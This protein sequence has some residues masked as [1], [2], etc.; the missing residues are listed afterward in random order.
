MHE[1]LFLVVCPDDWSIVFYLLA[2]FP[3]PTI[4][5]T[6]RWAPQAEPGE[7]S[8]P[9][10]TDGSWPDTG[11]LGWT[12]AKSGQAHEPQ[13]R[14]VG[15][16]AER[17]S[18]GVLDTAGAQVAWAALP[19]NPTLNTTG[20]PQGMGCLRQRLCSQSDFTRWFY[21]Q[22]QD[23]RWGSRLK[24]L[25][26]LFCVYCWRWEADSAQSG[27]RLS[28]PGTAFSL[29]PLPTLFKNIHLSSLLFLS[30][31][32]Q[33]LSY[34]EIHE[35]NFRY[36]LSFELTHVIRTISLRVTPKSGSWWKKEKV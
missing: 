31:T 20:Q 33:C 22:W 19:G 15:R 4:S 12:R 32:P 24:P 13:V 34:P 36:Q 10:R 35:W 1:G 23:F 3:S 6:M 28:V 16:E 25:S 2:A 29:P 18:A 11:L 21:K 26:S 5:P 8:P 17:P 30:L 9:A 14:G 7:L 27:P